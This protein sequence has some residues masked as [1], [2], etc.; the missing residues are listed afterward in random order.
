[1]TEKHFLRQIQESAEIGS[2]LSSI[3]KY[4][5]FYSATITSDVLIQFKYNP[6]YGHFLMFF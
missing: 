1:M 6:V 3:E 4:F 2:F 5:S